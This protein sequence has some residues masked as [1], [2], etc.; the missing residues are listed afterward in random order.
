[1]KLS[2]NMFM[3][4]DGVVQSP[5]GPDED[6]SGGFTHGG[7]VMPHIGDDWGR[8]VGGWFDRTEALLFGRFTY[9][10]MAAFWPNI[11]DPGDPVAS[12]LNTR[13]KYVVSSTL[14]DADATWANSTVVR[15]DVL[16][17][18][19]ELKE[20]AGDELQIHGSAR[21][22]GTLHAAGLVDV[23]RLLVFPVTVGDGKRLFDP[24]APAAGF[25]TVS[26]ETLSTGVTSLVLE[27][28]PFSAGGVTIVD[29]KVE[30]HVNEG[31]T[32]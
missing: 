6:P 23:Y 18:V 19:R 14:A 22:A 3:T 1:M 28:A 7:W 2:V 9:Q 8:V 13:R 12:R 16:T 21:L 11:T 27:P 10:A 4:L 31:A 20:Q 32:S 17:A 26:A 24:Q 15:G 5:G 29:S 30:I 25:R